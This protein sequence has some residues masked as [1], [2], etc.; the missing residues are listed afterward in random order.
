MAFFNNYLN[1]LSD[2]LLIGQDLSQS[3]SVAAGLIHKTTND[4]TEVDIIHIYWELYMQ[5]KEICFKTYY[6]DQMHNKI[7]LYAKRFNT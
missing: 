1:T 7:Q 3:G 6:N 2:E 4:T 5:L